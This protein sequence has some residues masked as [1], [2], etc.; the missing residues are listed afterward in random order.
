MEE[1]PWIERYCIYSFDNYWAWM[2]YKDGSITPAGQVYRDHRSTFAY[3]SKYTK[4]PSWWAP[5]AKTP[6]LETRY[7]EVDQTITVQAG[8]SGPK[9]EETLQ[10]APSLFGARRAYTCG[11]FPQSFEYSSV[12]GWT[13]TRGAGQNSTYYGTI[14]DIVLSLTR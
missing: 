13:V 10:N 12:G 2:F 4:T 6:A 9:L 11:H 14:A 8:M 7:N 5:S 1:C 3:D